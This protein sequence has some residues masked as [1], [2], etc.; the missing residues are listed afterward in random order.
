MFYIYNNQGIFKLTSERAAT[1]P[2]FFVT[3]IQGEAE[4]L[5][6]KLN[7]ATTEVMIHHE[8]L[9]KRAKEQFLREYWTD[10]RKALLSYCKDIT[11]EDWEGFLHGRSAT[12]SDG[13]CIAYLYNWGATPVDS[14]TMGYVKT[15]VPD[16][17]VFRKRDNSETI[18]ALLLKEGQE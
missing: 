12:T 8:I 9:K 17:Y 1:Q 13:Q 6:S 16:I 3:S 5:V 10:G 4:E 11:P 14:T 15:N 18:V 7:R 2:P